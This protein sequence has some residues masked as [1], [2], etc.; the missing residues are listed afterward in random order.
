MA[1]TTIVVMTSSLMNDNQKKNSSS[2]DEQSITISSFTKDQLQLHEHRH[3]KQNSS[4]TMSTATMNSVWGD[5]DNSMD[6]FNNVSISCMI[7]NNNKLQKLVRLHDEDDDLIHQTIHIMNDHTL[8]ER[9]EMFYTYDEYRRMK[10]EQRADITSGRTTFINKATVSATNKK[11]KQQHQQQNDTNHIVSLRYHFEKYYLQKHKQQQESNTATTAAA[12]TNVTTCN[13]SRSRLH[14]PLR[15]FTT[16][17]Q[18]TKQQHPQR[19]LQPTIFI[20]NDSQSS[21][22]SFNS[23]SSS[24]MSSSS[25]SLL[26]SS[27]SDCYLKEWSI[28]NGRGLENMIVP[29][30]NERCKQINKDILSC[31]RTLIK[32]EEYDDDMITNKLSELC[33]ELNIESKR[34]AHMLAIGDEILAK[35]YYAE[36]NIDTNSKSNNFHLTNQTVTKHLQM[37]MN[38]K[39]NNKS[40]TI[41]SLFRTKVKTI[42]GNIFI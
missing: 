23:S 16:T 40:N 35:E 8:L 28:S 12:G 7:M 5:D 21:L 19:G 34:I 11:K 24:L 22:S 38:K 17:P 10:K 20:A 18:L 36:N 9:L 15:G 37:K 32:N 3:Q 6:E 14:L 29:T 2:D 33:Q 13:N 26:S 27:S 41:Y 25:S 31:Y 42:K 30:L 39:N 1:S 4:R